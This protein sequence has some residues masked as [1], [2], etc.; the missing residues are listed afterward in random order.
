MKINLI[1]TERVLSKTQISIADYV[2][3]PYRGC[4]F[5]CA[6][7]YSSINKTTRNRTWGDFL[8]VKI[9]APDILDKELKAVTPRRVL[10]GSTTECF[11]YPELQYRVTGKI[12]ALLNDREVPY[13]ILTRS[14]AITRYIPLLKKNPWNKVYF[15]LGTGYPLFRKTFESRSPTF[16]KR[17]S[18]IMSLRQENIPFRIHLSPVIPFFMDIEKIFSSIAGLTDEVGIEFYNAKMGSEV[19]FNALNRLPGELRGQIQSVYAS[20]EAYSLY[21][22][23]LQDHCLALNKKY[24]FKLSFVF[25]PYDEYYSNTILYEK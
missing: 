20:N 10:L 4:L 5:G 16:E 3:N 12:L 13:T 17:L 14:D 19:F 8:D 11:Q 7:C 18:T 22:K 2:I 23:Q 25:P 24:G 6:Y 15:T 21:F 9:N 1:K